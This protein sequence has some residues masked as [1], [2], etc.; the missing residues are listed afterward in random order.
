MVVLWVFALR[1]VS[2]YLTG[3]GHT[4]YAEEVAIDPY[5]WCLREFFRRLFN[6][7]FPVNY[8]N[9]QCDKIAAF[10][11]NNLTVREYLHELNQMWNTIGEQSDRLKVDKFWKGL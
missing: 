1:V 4:F 6:Y 8:R 2:H 3:K 9:L 11:Q 5:S 10:L 7:C